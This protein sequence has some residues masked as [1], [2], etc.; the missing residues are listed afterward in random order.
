MIT[1]DQ[2]KEIIE[3]YAPNY[4]P[5]ISGIMHVENGSY[6]YAMSSYSR[7]RKDCSNVCCLSISS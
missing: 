6:N 2:K 5:R 3:K 1:A 7:V 4:T